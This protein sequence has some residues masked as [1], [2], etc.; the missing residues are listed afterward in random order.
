MYKF[1]KIKWEEWEYYGWLHH[2]H[3]SDKRYSGQFPDAPFVMGYFMGGLIFLKHQLATPWADRFL[4]GI[5]IRY[6]KNEII[7]DYEMRN[8]PEDV[9]TFNRDQWLP[10]TFPLFEL[11]PEMA[12]M[13]FKRWRKEAL[14]NPRH[15]LFPNQWLHFKM[16]FN[17]SV[18]K[19]IRIICELIDRFNIYKAR[20][21]NSESSG[22][23]CGYR[24]AMI[25]HRGKETFMTKSNWRY[26]NKNGW[27]EK[28]MTIYACVLSDITMVVCLSEHVMNS[29][30]EF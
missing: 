10:F 22:I 24:I 9:R 21:K 30:L 13:Q 29:L 23:H 16:S 19:P 17:E 6:Y 7:R 11:Y 18:W 2:H 14:T 26:L 3:Q 8:N 5:N 12:R 1:E 15:W 25:D 4:Y 28:A 20:K 27:L